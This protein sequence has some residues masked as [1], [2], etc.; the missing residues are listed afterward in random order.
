M[1]NTPNPQEIQSLRE[2]WLKNLREDGSFIHKNTANTFDRHLSRGESL[3]TYLVG[4]ELPATDLIRTARH[5]AQNTVSLL[6][7]KRLKV[8]VGG[9]SS[10]SVSDSVNVA[11]DY[12]DDPSLS[13][14][15]K[16][17]IL[18]GLAVHEA[19]HI[20][21]TDFDRLQKEANDTNPV[22]SELKRRIW[23]TLEDERIEYITGEHHPGMT[24]YLSKVKQHYFGK[25][26]IKEIES[27]TEPLPRLLNTLHLCVRYPAEMSEQMITDC[28]SELNKIK[29]ILTP[30]PL[31]TEEV[32]TATE[33]IMEIIRDLFRN[34]NNQN[35]QQDTKRNDQSDSQQETSN[36]NSHNDNQDKEEKDK[37]QQKSAETPE[38]EAQTNKP[39]SGK[40]EA[41]NP[42]T[43]EKNDQE[44]EARGQDKTD[45]KISE[46][47]NTSQ[48][49]EVMKDIK[50]EQEKNSR[51]NDSSDIRNSSFEKDYANDDAYKERVCINNHETV[52]QIRKSKGDKS[53]YD[54]SLNRVRKYIPSVSRALACKTEERDWCLSGEK[55]GKLNLNKL[56][57]LR[58]GNRA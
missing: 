9:N 4:K 40:P 21:N 24:D 38:K 29:D 14:G 39:Q 17:D 3:S 58:T 18:I 51:D 26:A 32:W 35:R 27:I 48:A 20:N 53:T 56:P 52:C 15:E 33:R 11:T 13:P 47:M 41:D 6:T 23:N 12:F 50:N 36:Q 2:D 5:L 34:D 55:T 30:Y 10:Y 1:N 22:I 57:S 37:N 8:T 44:N 42:T 16:T 49:K 25:R 31:T 54:K 43:E 46:A 45:R 19:S 7:G 28:Y